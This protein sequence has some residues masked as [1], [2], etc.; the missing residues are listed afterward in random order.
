MYSLERK[1]EVT[2][3]SEPCVG[4][5]DAAEAGGQ[6]AWSP[7]EPAHRGHKRVWISND[8]EGKGVW[9]C[10]DAGQSLGRCRALNRGAT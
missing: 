5:W 3:K 9:G 6:T 8:W 7:V 1:N 10:R 4:R 2:Q